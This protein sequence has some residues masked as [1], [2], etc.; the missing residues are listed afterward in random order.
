VFGVEPV[1]ELAIASRLD[2]ELYET[3]SLNFL[4]EDH[5]LHFP[6][7]YRPE[8]RSALRPY[9]EPVYSDHPRLAHWIAP[10]QLVPK[11][12]ETFSVLDRTNRRIHSD[13]A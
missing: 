13:F 7:R 9:L 10:L 4:V 2:V 5:A 3:R 6:L 12:T 1:T 8:E 11:N